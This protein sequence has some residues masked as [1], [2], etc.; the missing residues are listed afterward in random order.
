MKKMRKLLSLLLTASTVATLFTGCGR[1]EDNKT[2]STG[3]KSETQSQTGN[4]NDAVPPPSSENGAAP[5]SSSEDGLPAMTTENITLTYLN[6]DDQVTTE[7]LAEKFTEKYPNIE[8]VVQ[9]VE[10]KDS[11]NTLMNLIGAGQTPDC[12][13]YSDC[14]YA[15]SH[16]LLYDMTEYWKADPENKELLPTINELKLGYYFSDK[17]WGTPMKFFPGVV[18]VDKN[19]LETLNIDM[20][21]T[22]WTWNEMIDLIKNATDLDQSPAYYGLG[23]YHRLDSLYGIAAG[24]DV[25]GEFG[26]NGKTFDLSIWAIGE[27][28]FADLKISNYVAPPQNSPGME[29]WMGAYDFWHGQSGRVAI[30]TEA[31]WTFMNL[32]DKQEYRDMGLLYV[33]YVIPSV[34]ETEGVHNSIASLDFGGISSGTEHPREAYELLKFMG[35]GVDGWKERIKI[36]NDEGITNLKGEPLIRAG[37][38]APITMNQEVWDEYRKLYPQDEVEGPYWDRYFESCTRPIP[39]GWMQIPGYWTFCDEYFNKLGIHDLVDAGKNKAIDFA[40]EATEQANDYFAKAM[41]TY[42]GIDVTSDSYTFERDLSGNT[43][44]K[45][46][47]GSES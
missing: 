12:F 47:F 39:F 41:D 8:V 16:E 13:M 31:Y 6:F 19:E 34:E 29:Q 17:K 1:N 21:P 42:F 3:Q 23:Y 46:S 5:P 26:F 25:I 4:K 36:Y 33:P 24:Q 2:T 10:A 43:D 45:L 9:Y 32:W 20:P 14:D 27:Q 18:F 37:M 38:P 7:K 15:L 40:E 44:A 11:N 22:D 35:W 30:E 28:E